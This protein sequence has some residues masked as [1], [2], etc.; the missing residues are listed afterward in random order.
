MRLV[1]AVVG[2]ARNP[3][4]GQAIRDYETRAARYW[5]LDVH[6]VREERASGNAIEKVKD[7]EGARLAERIPDGA[8]T[9]ACEQG[10]R[11]LDSSQFAE[12]LKR[13][14]EDDRDV[15][16]LIGGA[17]GL[18]TDVSSRAAFKLALA[19]WTLPHEIARLVLVEQIYRA[20]TIVRGEPY[21]K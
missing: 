9:I 3:A 12:L 20:G 11:T 15:A 17:F 6:E 14:R 10:G 18:T 16:F 4:L 7:K 5:P 13:A 1:V 19:P 2:K 8:Q 21:H